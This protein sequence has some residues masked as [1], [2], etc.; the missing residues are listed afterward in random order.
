[1]LLIPGILL[2]LGIVAVVG[3]LL[4]T[5][6]PHSAMPEAL[7]NLVS[8]SNVQVQMDPWLVFS[9]VDGNLST[10]LILYP[11]GLVDPAAY[12]PAG[13]EIAKAGYLVIIPPMPL[14]LAVFGFTVAADIMDTYPETSNWAIGGHSLGGSMA[15]LYVDQNPGE[16]SGLVLWASY[17]AK[18]N[19][20]SDDLILVSSIYGT[21]DGLVTSKEVRE[22]Q[23]RLP[24]DTV[25]VPIEGGNH[26][27]F[28]W[29]GPQDG[30]NPAIIDRDHQ[31][32]LI[33][34]STLALLS[35]I[36]K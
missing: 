35:Q 34:E 33:V 4:W 15:A 19:N 14:N 29:Y 12:A 10:G 7:E 31:Q 3:F 13:R 27:Q 36:G 32:V 24:A 30:D 11:G 1:V 22:S 5:R 9:P 26:S 21:R 2:F 28:G 23:S 8:D 16:I 6:V 18:M 20:L 25:W 17:P